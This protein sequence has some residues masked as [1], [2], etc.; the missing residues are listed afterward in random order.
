MGSSSA[1]PTVRNADVVWLE[2][3]IPMAYLN[4]ENVMEMSFSIT[5]V[6][7]IR[8]RANKLQQLLRWQEEGAVVERWTENCA[9]C[10]EP[11]RLALERY[12]REMWHTELERQNAIRQIKPD[13]SSKW[14]P[15]TC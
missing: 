15:Q 2:N 4:P 7:D 10:R 1:K 9:M 6:C 11:S 14:Q 13:L 5:E 12:I 8:A 3:W